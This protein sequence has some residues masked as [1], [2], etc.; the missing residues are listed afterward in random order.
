ME[1]TVEEKMMKMETRKKELKEK[2]EHALKI[3]EDL[4]QEVDAKKREMAKSQRELEEIQSSV[5]E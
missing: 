3:R 4:R 2:Y 1:D 5:T